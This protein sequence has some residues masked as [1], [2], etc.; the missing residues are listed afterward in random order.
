MKRYWITWAVLLCITLVMLWMDSVEFARPLFIAT[1]VVAMLA[2]ATIIS[3]TFMHLRHEH[4]AII[5]TVAFG[6]L[7]TGAILYVLIIPDAK[8]IHQMVQVDQPPAAAVALER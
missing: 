7:A 1:M 4:K 3:G 6:L 8:R 5:M 2:K